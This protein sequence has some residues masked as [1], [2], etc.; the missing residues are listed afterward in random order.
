MSPFPRASRRR[1]TGPAVSGLKAG[2][3]FERLGRLV[4]VSEVA[5]VADELNATEPFGPGPTSPVIAAV[6]VVAGVENVELANFGPD[7]GPVVV[8]QQYG[9]VPGVGRGA[10]SGDEDGWSDFA[11]GGPHVVAGIVRRL[12][13]VAAFGQPLPQPSR[14]TAPP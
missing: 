9:F 1:L 8:L 4:D 7:C 10:V 3:E 14:C 11:A 13:G 2:R 12:D 5:V 6:R